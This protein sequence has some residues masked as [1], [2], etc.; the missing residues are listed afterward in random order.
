VSSITIGLKDE[1]IKA[2]ARLLLN[3]ESKKTEA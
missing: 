2:L 3:K 1:E